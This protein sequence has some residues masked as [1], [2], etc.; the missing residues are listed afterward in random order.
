MIE[1]TYEETFNITNLDVS[2]NGQ[3]TVSLIG[4]DDIDA[5]AQIKS[6]ST[7]DVTG[8]TNGLIMGIELADGQIND[9][10]GGNNNG[11]VNG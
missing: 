3:S 2:I 4:A 6:H 11:Q 10:L 5:V 9:V 8:Q 7:G 1:G